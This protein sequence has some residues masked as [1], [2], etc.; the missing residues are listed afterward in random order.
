[1]SEAVATTCP[2]CGVGCGVLARADAAGTVSVEGDPAHASN[3][4]RLCVKG[5]ALGET[6]DL[7]GRLL[8]PQVRE[9]DGTYRRA[10]WDEALDRVADGFRRT[11]D[12]HGPDPVA[13]Y[14][15]GQLVTEEYKV[16]T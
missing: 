2:Y 14:V 15:S 6:T 3:F 13:V 4:G 11:I 16:V 5:A 10:G 12:Q 7:R 9:P 8:Y 1:M